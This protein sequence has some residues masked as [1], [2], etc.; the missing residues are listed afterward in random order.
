M[1][2]IIDI[3]KVFEKKLNLADLLEADFWSTSHGNNVSEGQSTYSGLL[4]M[5]EQRIQ[6]RELHYKYCFSPIGTPTCNITCHNFRQ[7]Q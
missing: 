1:W 4:L 6:I 7:I 3:E 5:P 2:Y